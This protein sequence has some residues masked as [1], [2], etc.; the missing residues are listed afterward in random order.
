M[1]SMK[2]RTLNV[3]L[4][5]DHAVVREGLQ[6]ILEA[7]GEIACTQRQSAEE[8]IELIAG[9]APLDVVLLDISLSGMSGLDAIA[10]IH[11]LRPKLP[12]VLIS[13]LPE[14]QYAR[15]ALRLGAA[16]Y[17]CKNTASAEVVRAVQTAVQGEIYLSHSVTQQVARGGDEAQP[18][19]LHESLSNREFMILRLIGEGKPVGEIA[20][21]LNLSVKTVS[22]YRSRILDKMKMSNNYEIV[23]YALQEGLIE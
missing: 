10:E 1:E 21:Q 3:L 19:P 13:M 18:H 9:S 16:G 23:R 7:T 11:K 4:I 15:R 14:E 6:S 2:L 5:D 20:R 22:T 17:L 8:A 12:V